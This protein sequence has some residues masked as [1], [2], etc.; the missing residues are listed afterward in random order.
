MQPSPPQRISVSVDFIG[1]LIGVWL[2]F[3]RFDWFRRALGLR[4]KWRPKALVTTPVEELRKQASI[5]VK[6]LGVFKSAALLLDEVGTQSVQRSC[7]VP[8]V[9]H[10]HGVLRDRAIRARVNVVDP[11][12]PGNVSMY[13]GP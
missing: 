2:R 6:V 10:S 8:W 11:I 12:P 4:S 13:S 1:V 7:F 3:V 9:F 5:A